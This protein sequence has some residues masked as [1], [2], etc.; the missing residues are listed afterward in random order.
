MKQLRVSTSVK[1]STKLSHVV[2]APQNTVV[3][4]LES[5]ESSA[6]GSSQSAVLT[7][8]PA[9][10]AI[11]SDVLAAEILWAM[12]MCSSHYSHKSSESSVLLCQKMFPDSVC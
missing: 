5:G 11:K 6:S 4:V 7:S 10:V 3:K 9:A 8:I 12:K 2:A 1:D